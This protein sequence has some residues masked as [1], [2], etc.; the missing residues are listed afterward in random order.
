MKKILAISAAILSLFAV[1]SCEQEISG[2]EVLR[3]KTVINAGV[4][5]TKTA[6]GEKDGPSW[7]NYWKTGDQINVNGVVSE[8]LG[9]EADGQTWAKF[10]FAGE[11]ATPHCSAYPAAAVSNYADGA[12]TLTVPATQNYVEASYDPAAFVMFGK[13]EDETKVSLN[14]LVSVI[15]LTVKGNASVSS[16]K[17]TG[18]AGAALSGSFTTDFVTVVPGTVSNVVELV[19]ATPV[20]LPAEF[21]ICVPE[22]VS[23]DI[24]IEI[25]DSEAGSI[26]KKATLKNTLVAGRVYSPAPFVYG[27]AGDFAIDADSI[28]SSTAVIFWR[29]SSESAYTIGVY[30][31]AGCTAVIDSYSV[32]AGNTCW[33]D[34]SPRFC[35]SGLAPGLDYFVRVKDD[36]NNQISDI[37]QVTTKP[38]DIIQ[39][40][41]TEVGVGDVILSE[42]FGELRWDCDVVGEGVGWF[43]T[44]AAQTTSFGTVEVASYQPVNTS[45][46]KQLSVQA[47]PVAASRLANWA[48]GANKN[49]YIHP[50][51][52]KLVG[53][54]KVTHIVTPAFDCIPEGKSATLEVE[55]TASAYYSESS[56]SFAT[57]DAIVAVQPSGEYKELKDND[58]NTLDLTGNVQEI[59]LSEDKAWHTYTVI[60]PDV[61]RGARLAFGASADVTGNNARMNI[62]DMKVTVKSLENDGSFM[63]ITNVSDLLEFADVVA[64]GNKTINARVELS[65]TKMTLS[66]SAKNAFNTIEDYR[67]TFD[68]NGKTI[69]GLTKPMFGTLYGTVRDLTLESTVVATDPADVNWGI[70][71][72]VLSTDSKAEVATLYNCKSKGS[73]NYTPSA[74]LSSD[75]QLGGLVGNNKGGTINKCMNLADVTLGGNGVSN[76]S[77]TSVGGVVGR[78]QKNSDSGVQGK[79]TGCSNYGSANCNAALSENLYIGGVVGYQVEK[80]EKMSECTNSGVVKVGATGSSAKALHIGGVIGMGKGTIEACSNLSGSEV[81]TELGSSAGTYLCQGG[82]VGRLNRE[83]DSYSGLSNAGTLNVGAAGGSSYRLIGGVVG[84]CDEGASITELTNSGSINYS[85]ETTYQTFI[86]G[87]VATNGVDELV[88]DACNSTG[89]TI[90]YTGATTNGNL[91]I[92]GIVGYSK[93]PVF[94]CTN[95]MNINIGGEFEAEGNKYYATGGIVG[96]MSADSPISDCLNTGNITWS[97][98]ITGAGYVF[99]GGVAGRT[100]GSIEDSSNGGTV[101]ITGK[102]GAQ[103]PFYGGV[104]GSTDSANEHSITGKYASATATNYGAVVVN[105]EVQSNKYIYVGGVAGRLHTNGSMT[106]T[107]NGPVTVSRLKC[108][109][110]Y[111][112]GLT[113]LANGPIGS[114]SKN[115]SAGD[116]SV[117]N[118]T[119]TYDTY[120]GGLVGT[121]KFAVTGDNDGDITVAEGCK[122]SRSY[123]VG[124][125][126][127]HVGGPVTSSTNKGIITTGAQMA[128]GK[129]YY[130]QIGGIA[131]YNNGDAPIENCS[132]KADVTNTGDSGGYLYVGGITS[133]SDANILTCV[134]AA[135][136]T[137]SG[138]SGNGRPVC[139]GGVAG[140]ASEITVKDCHNI[141][142][143]SNTGTGADSGTVGTMVGGLIGY[144]YKPAVLTGTA[145]KYNYNSGTVSD[146]S[147]STRVAIGGV[148]GC[149]AGAG[150]DMK[151]AKN[152]DTGAI[153]YQ[154]NTRYDSHIGGVLGCSTAAFSMDNAS[155]AAGLTIK[156]ITVSHQVFLGGVI[157]GITSDAECTF[158]NLTNSGMISC[159]SASSGAN[160]AAASASVTAMTY[161][162]GIAGIGAR[163]AK[164]FLNCS[165]SGAI[166]V[167]NQVP[168]RMGGI[169]GYATENPT[170]CVNTGPINYCRYN[171]KENGT[172]GVV[173]GIVGYMGIPNPHDLTND[174]TVRTTGSSPNCFTGGIVGQGS[175]GTIAFTN[176]YVGTTNGD[177]QDRHTISGAGEKS[178]TNGGSAGLF[179][180]VSSK[181]D[182]DFKGCKIKNGT[183]CQNVVID[184]SNMSDAVVGR[185]N[186]PS[187][188]TNPPT[189]VDTF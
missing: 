41:Q 110:L 187:N 178:F 101:T 162:G 85:A 38:F 142:A 7:P 22:G 173:G 183:K 24:E 99:V 146:T 59:T 185:N 64:A 184:E 164:T 46:E 159:P 68:G 114:G 127:G 28:T 66:Q 61:P 115:M 43:P 161:I 131:G 166:A 97:Q 182:W 33:G 14:P 105:T 80:A 84:R 89:G 91:Y 53:S 35:I 133:E 177:S 50:G 150:T 27:D 157:G 9:E 170:G 23:G 113:G 167:Y 155:N 136:V 176:C 74:A 90:T 175:S 63:L 78:T 62:S 100:A 168:V 117:A 103:N 129:D 188:I 57:T 47:V 58:V 139:I 132:N 92:G 138:S 141:G 18:E 26:T 11:I 119:T 154:G 3:T 134:N 186:H 77:Q 60:V 144:V 158:S 44:E 48:Q 95:A 13:S 169:L 34:K 29:G 171:P 123:F 172:T 104:V 143:V 121:T 94:N 151:Y 8:A 102:S 54:G 56:A 124:G 160:M 116:I 45:G 181:R 42:D 17:I 130:M 111:L 109:I 107:N 122:T 174:A 106:A 69:V 86:G 25:T 71:A 108:T 88:L 148:V 96:S 128:G 70:L 40:P 30:Y 39:V 152:L 6:L 51:Y 21:F 82:V 112:G 72:K 135:N 20:N 120:I 149:N 153:T 189:F 4:A 75:C 180:S 118:L 52:L 49:I 12:A 37:L 2:P 87:I 81:T 125:I 147:E 126:V 165:N 73:I 16:I 32:E 67:G 98:Q 179:I 5:Q 163:G 65:G 137:N 145:S 19:A 1:V 140:V 83:K 156:S 55:I 36:T 79:I 10:T 31:D 15:H 93:R 76:S